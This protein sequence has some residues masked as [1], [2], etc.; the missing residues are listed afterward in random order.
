MTHALPLKAENRKTRSQARSCA[1]PRFHVF[2]FSRFHAPAATVSFTPPTNMRLLRLSAFWP[3]WPL[4]SRRAPGPIT[5]IAKRGVHTLAMLATSHWRPRNA[6]STPPHRVP[7]RLSCADRSAL[8]PKEALGTLATLRETS[9]R[10]RLVLRRQLVELRQREH[11]AVLA[12]VD[13]AH[14]AAAA[15]AHAAL[16]PVLQRR[17]RSAPA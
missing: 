11:R 5:N 12:D 8:L 16:H 13:L 6:G 10:G 2:T 17:V 3:A 14:V 15:L 7:T 1:V 4:T 9:L